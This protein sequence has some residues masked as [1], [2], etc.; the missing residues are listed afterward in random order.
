MKPDDILDP[1]VDRVRAARE[2]L[3]RECDY[4]LNKMAKL[5]KSMQD[6]HPERVRDPRATASHRRPH[7]DAA[8][9]E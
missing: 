7:A 9:N 3:A 1:V 5:F 2:A 6:V 4:D 8:K